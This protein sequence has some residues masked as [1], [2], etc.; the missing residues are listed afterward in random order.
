M[1][2]IFFC[3]MVK[4]EISTSKYVEMVRKYLYLSYLIK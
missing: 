1:E 3:R 4:I 2:Y